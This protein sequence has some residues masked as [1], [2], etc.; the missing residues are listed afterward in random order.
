MKNKSDPSG[1]T[2][3]TIGIRCAKLVQ[4]Y[5]KCLKVEFIVSKMFKKLIFKFFSYWVLLNDLVRYC[6]CYSVEVIE[7]DVQFGVFRSST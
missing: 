6:N 3:I 4:K 2:P 5:I 1:G 7:R